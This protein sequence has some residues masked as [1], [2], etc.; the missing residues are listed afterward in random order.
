MI[1]VDQK[2]ILHHL[3]V[4]FERPLWKNCVGKRCSEVKELSRN[5]IK[6]FEVF[7]HSRISKLADTIIHKFNCFFISEMF[8]FVVI[9]V[10]ICTLVSSSSAITGGLTFLTFKEGTYDVQLGIFDL[11]TKTSTS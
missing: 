3:L 9:F 5:F 8:V 4:L 10:S 11:V 6:F 1:Q 2:P 7:A